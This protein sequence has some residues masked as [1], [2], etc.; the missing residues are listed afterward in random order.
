MRYLE[1][2]IA[3]VDVAIL[4]R[5]NQWA[6]WQRVTTDPRP[7]TLHWVMVPTGGGEP[8]FLLWHDDL[9]ADI[10]VETDDF[11]SYT[12]GYCVGENVIYAFNKSYG[13]GRSFTLL[14][15]SNRPEFLGKDG[16]GREQ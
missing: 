9:S 10:T 15:G 13:G 4:R 16:D 8:D 5:P 1:G 11:S 12:W 14:K 6:G 3:D 7:S 2:V